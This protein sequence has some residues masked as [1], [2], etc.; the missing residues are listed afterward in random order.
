MA[1]TA[2]QMAQ[3]GLAG[4]VTEEKALDIL[5]LKAGVDP[6][7]RRRSTPELHGRQLDIKV[8]G[9]LQRFFQR[10]DV[11]V[12]KAGMVRRKA[13]Y[14]E[15]HREA[16]KSAREA[17]VRE[18]VGVPQAMEKLASEDVQQMKAERVEAWVRRQDCLLGLLLK[19]IAANGATLD[20]IYAMRPAMEVLPA[21][22]QE[23]LDKVIN[24]ATER[25]RNAVCAFDQLVETGK[26]L[27]KQLEK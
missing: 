23:A 17:I 11:Y 2:E 5:G 27:L 9:K 20:V 3:P 7:H 21:E 16:L 6:L 1:T 19:L 18:A 14:A 15:M 4:F 10:T 26:V 8:G 25:R 13:Q 12:C 24:V 22:Q